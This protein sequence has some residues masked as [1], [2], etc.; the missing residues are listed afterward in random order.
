MS[1][2]KLI[3]P[4]LHTVAHRNYVAVGG[5]CERPERVGQRGLRNGRSGLGLSGRRAFCLGWS[6]A[7]D[8]ARIW[9]FWDSLGEGCGDEGDRWLYIYI[10]RRWRKAWSRICDLAGAVEAIWVYTV[11]GWQ[12]GVGIGLFIYG[13]GAKGKEKRSRGWLD[14]VMGM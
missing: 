7:R 9:A 13:L 4:I 3:Y 12:A 8:V 5:V 2:A 14:L 1:S 10:Y 11:G 6:A